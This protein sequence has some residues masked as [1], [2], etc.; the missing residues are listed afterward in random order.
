MGG[1]GLFFYFHAFSIIWKPGQFT[2]FEATSTRRTRTFFNRIF[3]PG[4]CRQ[5]LKPLW[6][7]VS[8]RCVFGGR[9][10][11]F[12]LPCAHPR[13]AC[14]QATTGL[15]NSCGRLKPDINYVINLK[16][17]T[18]MFCLQV[19][20]LLLHSFKSILLFLT[21][22][23]SHSKE[24]LMSSRSCNLLVRD[25]GLLDLIVFKPR[26]RWFWGRPARASA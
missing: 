6:R 11:W 3:Y 20:W 26:Q 23:T 10:L 4:S 14:S 15:V 8:K 16:W 22:N 1:G 12:L 2:K 21:T 24:D 9:I 25:E 18:T 17:W 5:G 7:A 13:R 19:C